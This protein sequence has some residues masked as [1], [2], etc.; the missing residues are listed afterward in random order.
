MSEIVT[1]A[2]GFGLSCTRTGKG[3]SLLLG[4]H[5]GPGGGGG[6]Y[7]EPLHRLAGD[8]RTVVTFDQLGTGE[9]TVPPPDYQWTVEKAAADVEAV[10]AH[11]GVDQVELLGH[12]WGGMLALE[13]ALT[14]PGRVSRLVL[15]NTG[16]SVPR[17]VTEYFRQLI[18]LLP[19]RDAAAALTADLLGDHGNPQFTTAVTRWL[20]AYATAGEETAEVL[21][22]GP[23]GTGLWGDRLWFATAALRDWDVEDRL[24][25]IAVPALVIH[26]GRDMSTV[27]VNRVMAEG[28]PDCEWITLQRGGHDLV[29]EPCVGAYL[30]IL[31]AFLDG[32]NDK[33]ETG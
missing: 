29:D 8:D 3:D 15:S 28:I 19:P 5:G 17:V 2:E 12:S 22:S 16:A 14:F 10:R 13:Y 20:A 7:L 30:A 21:D 24:G 32:W 33:E 4:L 9:S 6:G 1:T 23:A 26:G 31:G 25:E 11:Y 18:D 27:D